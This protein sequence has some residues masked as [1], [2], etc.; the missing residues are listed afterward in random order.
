[1][2][3]FC[4]NLILMKVIKLL[5]FL[6]V[7]T[8]CGDDDNTPLQQYNI[9]LIDG[10]TD[11]PLGD[12]PI[13]LFYSIGSQGLGNTSGV[14]DQQ[15]FVTLDLNVKMDTIETTILE[16]PNLDESL[17]FQIINIDKDDYL[18]YELEQD[19]AIRIIRS[20]LAED[21]LII[22]KAYEKI[23][24]DFLIVDED[25][26]RSEDQFVF[27]NIKQFHPKFS[28]EDYGSSL[29]VFTSTGQDT[30]LQK[31]FL[32]REVDYRIDY[33][34]TIISDELTSELDTIFQSSIEFDA[35]SVL[36]DN[37]VVA[38]F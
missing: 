33:Y 2:Q 9:Q 11:I 7:I 6:L 15:G 16:N 14:T 34:V 1:M 35:Q 31:L 25:P 32:A 26:N 22:A 12:V 24:I 5:L 21:E 36:P 19:T 17:I 13:S 8:S 29:G 30:V 18:L 27:Y 28:F 37:V 4:H 20:I 23:E 38:K 3:S 10:L